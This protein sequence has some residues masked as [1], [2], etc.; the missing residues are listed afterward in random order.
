MKLSVFYHHVAQGAEQRNVTLPE[1]LRAVR[2]WG[3]EALEVEFSSAGGCVEC[4][5]QIRREGLEISSIFGFFDFLH[6]GDCRPAYSMVDTAAALDVRKVMAIPGFFQDGDLAQRADACRK[7]MAAAMNGLCDYAAR[8]GITVMTEDFD[9]G[10]SPIATG[11]QLVQL[12]GAV[13]ALKIAFDTG[14]F[15]FSG[16]N[17]I[18]AFEALRDRIVHVHCK[19]RSRSAASG[20]EPLICADGTRAYPVPVG[21]GCVPIRELLLRLREIG[22]DG[23]LAIEHFGAPDQLEYIRRSAAWLSALLHA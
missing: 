11:G 23:Y 12:C 20:G 16:E 14:N 6:T 3:V 1:A 19:D 15:M 2:G 8:C 21:E 17:E 5:E 10:A 7:N 9:N 13:P 18:A 22:Y 4:A